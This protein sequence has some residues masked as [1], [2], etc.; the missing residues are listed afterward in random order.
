MKEERRKRQGE[1][2]MGGK[3]SKGGKCRLGEGGEK[4]QENCRKEEEKERGN[5][6]G[7]EGREGG[8]GRGD[9]CIK[10]IITYTGK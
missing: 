8:E 3:E 1:R 5:E 4:K 7:K 2:R 10:H 6:G 9:R